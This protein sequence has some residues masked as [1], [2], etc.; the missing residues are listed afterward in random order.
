MAGIIHWGKRATDE[1]PDVQSEFRR[2]FRRA[3]TCTQREVVSARARP[4]VKY[5]VLKSLAGGLPSSDAGP[6]WDDGEQHV[7]TE[8]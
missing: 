4:S 3:L 8:S 6:T 5:E 7:R 1:I 2:Q